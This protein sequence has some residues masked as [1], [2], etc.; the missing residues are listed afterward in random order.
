[1]DLTGDEIQDIYEIGNHVARRGS[2]ANTV[3]ALPID[4]PFQIFLGNPRGLHASNITDGELQAAAAELSER[5]IYVHA[6]YTINLCR[7]SRPR[8]SCARLS[9]RWRSA[10]AASSFTSA[11]R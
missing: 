3:R 10:R 8:Y 9:R 2:I 5:R 6:A 4:R 1:M 11:S 7:P